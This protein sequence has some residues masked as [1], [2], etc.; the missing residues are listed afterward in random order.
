MTRAEAINLSVVLEAVKVFLE[1]Q[2]SDPELE[3]KELCKFMIDLN[4]RKNPQKELLK[5]ICDAAIDLSSRQKENKDLSGRLHESLQKMA[6]DFKE[7]GWDEQ[8][9]VVH[10][11]ISAVIMNYNP[12]P[13]TGV[14]EVVNP[15]ARVV[16]KASLAPSSRPIG[17]PVILPQKNSSCC[18]IS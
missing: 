11:T 8:C 2:K 9:N 12:P 4:E 16:P 15:I 3:L 17:I 18:I 10:E 5:I 1:K 13:K 7:K 14:V 6:D